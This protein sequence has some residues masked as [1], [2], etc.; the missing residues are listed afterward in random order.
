MIHTATQLKAKIRNLSESNSQKAQ[1]L[2]RFSIMERF[3]ERMAV[4]PYRDHFILKGG[5]LVSSIVGLKTRTTDDIDLTVKGLNLS[6]RNRMEGIIS[7]ILNIPLPDCISFRVARVSTIME[8][9]EHPGLRFMLEATLDR[10]QQ[11]IKVDLSC[12]DVLTP[13]PVNYEYRLLFEDRTIPVL[14]YNLETL[15]S[16]KLETVMSRGTVNTRM[17]DF[18]DLHILSHQAQFDKSLLRQAFLAI[19]TKRQ[20]LG[21]LPDFPAILDAVEADS[22]MQLHWKNYSQNVCFAEPVSFSE[23]MASI[24]QLASAVFI[25]TQ[26]KK[27]PMGFF[28]F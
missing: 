12:D 28:G 16:E 22:T 11:M 24:R 18:Y 2:I 23:V 6:D 15:L 21:Q 4:S 5:M 27:A 7:E 20:T 8:E 9:Y 26:H 10:L 17:R 25:R 14:A 19:C 3:L 13:G 1:T